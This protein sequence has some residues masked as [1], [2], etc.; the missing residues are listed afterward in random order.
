M[1][2]SHRNG[3]DTRAQFPHAMGTK[4]FPQ[5]RA[6][7]FRDLRLLSSV[8]CYH[9]RPSFPTDAAM[10]IVEAALE[11]VRRNFRLCVYAYVVMPRSSAVCEPQRQTP[12]MH[13]ECSGYRS[14][15]PRRM[16]KVAIKYAV[17]PDHKKAT[18]RLS[19]VG[20]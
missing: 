9:R 5:Y 11:R 17:P 12:L 3:A 8:G 19:V 7:S 14:A 10:R 6:K 1:F 4:A 13:T 16:R 2:I 18:L 15:Q 20:G